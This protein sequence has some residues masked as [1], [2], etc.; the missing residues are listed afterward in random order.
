MKMSTKNIAILESFAIVGSFDCD[1]TQM[2]TFFFNLI[3]NKFLAPLTTHIA[4]K[5]LQYS[6]INILCTIIGIFLH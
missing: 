2:F 5:N 4:K 3:K 6:L 1:R